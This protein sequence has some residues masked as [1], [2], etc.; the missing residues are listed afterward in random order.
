MQAIT[1]IYFPG[2]CAEAISFYRDTFKAELLFQLT[3]VPDSQ[4]AFLEPGSPGKIIR[5]G[6]RIGET[7]IYLSEGHHA[8]DT[9]FQGVSMALHVE[10]EN[11][12]KRILDALAEGGSIRIPLRR[13]AWA[14][15]FGAAVDRF[16]LYWTVETGA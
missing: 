2:L 16:G 9:V 11:E 14:A 1:T 4:P 3:A 7:V 10:D 5:A 12:V 13:T 15:C 6:L 8:G